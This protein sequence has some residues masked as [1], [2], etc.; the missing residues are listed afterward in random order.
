MFFTKHKTKTTPLFWLTKLS[1]K[2]V[3]ILGKNIKIN[4]EQRVIM[5]NVDKELKSL[6]LNK[7][8]QQRL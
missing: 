5:C 1:V 8:L 2:N 7:L 4:N 6:G 3:F